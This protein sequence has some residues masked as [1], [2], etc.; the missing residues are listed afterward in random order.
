[1]ID[2]IKEMVLAFFRLRNTLLLFIK[3]SWCQYILYLTQNPLSWYLFV[4]VAQWGP[5]RIT[6]N[7]SVMQFFISLNESYAQNRTRILIMDPLPP[8]TKVFA[9]V[10][11]EERQQTINLGIFSSSEHSGGRWISFS[12]F[13]YCLCNQFHSQTQARSPS[14]F[15]V[16]FTRS[17]C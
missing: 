16:W 14:L 5:G 15:S 13:C 4:T 12:F 8:I 7:K 10:V 3:G 17:Y 9:L 6:N 1:M 2:F 11:Q